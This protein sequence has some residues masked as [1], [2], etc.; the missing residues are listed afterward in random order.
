MH[1]GI[2]SSIKEQSI[3]SRDI[4]VNVEKVANMSDMNNEAV[5]DALGTVKDLESLA[6]SLENS[7]RHFKI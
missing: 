4:A 5:N 6:S 2:S 3:A 1:A 7:V